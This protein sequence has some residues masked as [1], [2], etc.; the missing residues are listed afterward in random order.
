MG[1]SSWSSSLYDEREKDRAVTGRSAFTYNAAVASGAAPAKTHEAMDPLNVK[2]NPNGVKVR[3][4]R[5]SG[6]HPETLAI[7]VFFDVTGSM[8]EIPKTLQKK[9]GGLMTLLISKGFVEHPAIMFGAI[10]DATC[11]RAPLQVGQFESGIELD[12]DLGKLYL[13][14]GG[15][16]TKHESY[17]LVPYFFARHTSIDCYEKRGVK[18]YLFTMGDELPYDYVRRVEVAKFL[19][20]A[21]EADI[22]IEQIVTE[23]EEHYHWFH[24]LIKEG[25]NFKA[26]STDTRW[27]ALLG[28]RCLVLDNPENVAE[29]VALTI[30]VNEGTVDVDTG[31]S[32]LAAAGLDPRAAKS[33]TNALAPLAAQA[34]LAK[35]GTASGIGSGAPGVTRL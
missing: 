25:D 8:R 34:S 14:G 10:G 19:G 35:A 16:G 31:A 4:A 6:D 27:K 9:L 3:E 15:G 5:D 11:D 21:L 33:I 22:P 13:E 28:E 18:G 26:G 32:H 20:D 7:G 30:G 1:G 29:A 24:L 12:D 2:V 23:V 17:E